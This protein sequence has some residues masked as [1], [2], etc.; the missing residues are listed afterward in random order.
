MRG[1]AQIDIKDLSFTL[2][3]GDLEAYTDPLL[4]R[5]F[6]NLVEN[7]IRHGHHV[8]EINISALPCEQGMM[9][10]Y[11]DNGCGVP[12]NLK[13][14]IFTHGFGKNT[15]LGLFLIREIL[16]MTGILIR[17]TGKENEG[18]RFEIILPKGGFQKREPDSIQ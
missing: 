5:V 2:S 1:I 3:L 14:L 9:I 10:V 8:T 15:G 11:E 16:G 12:A 6:Y 7:S 17:E 13:E 18:V 4:D